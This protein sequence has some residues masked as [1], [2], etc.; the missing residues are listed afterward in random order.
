MP[1]QTICQST[2]W[3][4]KGLSGEAGGRGR[5]VLPD[6]EKIEQL[7]IYSIEKEISNWVWLVSGGVDRSE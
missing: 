5:K 1:N 6:L 4:L 3:P 7:A 2:D